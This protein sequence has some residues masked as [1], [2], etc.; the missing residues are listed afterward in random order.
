[1]LRRSRTSAPR[2]AIEDHLEPG[3]IL[4]VSL[5]GLD[6]SM[7]GAPCQIFVTNRRLLWSLDARPDV[8]LDVLYADFLGIGINWDERDLAFEAKRPAVNN[9]DD[10][11]QP[12]SPQSLLC[13]LR[14]LPGATARTAEIT[15]QSLSFIS[16]TAGSYCSAHGDSVFDK[17]LRHY[18][19]Q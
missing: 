16:V 8:L 17:V 15:D 7:R 6:V 2:L 13:A 11:L 12:V 4:H 5:R 9:R 14:F 1:M 3:E 10:V 18:E 19:G